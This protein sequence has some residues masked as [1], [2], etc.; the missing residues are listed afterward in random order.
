MKSSARGGSSGSK[1]P[2]SKTIRN[3]TKSPAH[4][5]NYE[6][7]I[8]HEPLT[9]KQNSYTEEKSKYISI[10]DQVGELEQDLLSFN[11]EKKK[12]L[13]EMDKIDDTKVKTREMISRRRRL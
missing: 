10:L 12:L 6:N 13:N 5:N 3:T 9:H 2:N 7:P 11:T 1:T 4:R 8:S